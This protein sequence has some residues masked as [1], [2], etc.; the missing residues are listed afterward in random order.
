MNAA[1]SSRIL[2]VLIAMC[3]LA[4]ALSLA[5]CKGERAQSESGKDSRQVLED[6]SGF[7]AELRLAESTITTA[8]R[9]T[10]TINSSVRDGWDAQHADVAASLPENWRIV[11]DRT[12]PVREKVDGWRHERRMVT[13]E[14]FLDGEYAIGEIEFSAS[15]VPDGERV[16][17]RSAPFKLTVLSVLA[18]E[19]EAGLADVKSVVEPPA[20]SRAWIWAGVGAGAIV[21]V[22][23]ALWIVAHLRRPKLV[24]PER[25]YAHEVALE[26]LDMLLASDL[27]NQARFKEFYG[28]A[29]WILRRYI[30][31]RFGLHAPKQ[32]TEEFLAESRV[33][34][35]LSSDDVSSLERF[36]RSCDEVKFAAAEASHAQS[37]AVA[38]AVREFV[39]RTRNDT[40]MV[41]VQE[42]AAQT[43]GR[44]A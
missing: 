40:S 41:I 6:E 8:Q 44:A 42:Q 30:E 32:T 16:T 21:L 35:T 12:E 31:D 17:M 43:R 7:R 23:V 5:G 28:Q 2:L 15:P 33:S 25:R 20:P 9:L 10:L 11:E 24:E 29:S 3:M 36:L 39:L 1:V 4:V 37:E 22:A 34:L 14:P 26:R 27:L 38:D 13:V 19:D 18:P